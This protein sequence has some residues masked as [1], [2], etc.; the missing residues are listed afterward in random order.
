MIDRTNQCVGLYLY[1]DLTTSYAK[2]IAPHHF[3]DVTTGSY[4]E[5]IH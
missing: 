5:L 3:V 4:E 2:V 1:I